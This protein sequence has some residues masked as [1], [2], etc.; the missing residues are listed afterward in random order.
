M[1]ILVLFLIPIFFSIAQAQNSHPTGYVKKGLKFKTV[2]IARGDI[3]FAS[4]ELFV[5]EFINTS[6]TPVIIDN[7]QTSC[8]CTTA[9]KPMGEIKKRGKGKISVS[10]DTYRVGPFTKTITVTSNV[11]LPVVLTISGN[12]LPEK[13]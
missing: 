13:H 8:G 1:K 6:K 11:G 5:F 9:E 4:K 10:Y 2:E 7:V 3:E 12:V